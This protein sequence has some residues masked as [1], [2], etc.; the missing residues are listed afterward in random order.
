MSKTRIPSGGANIGFVLIM[1]AL[2][3]VVIFG[4]VGFAVDV[5]RVYDEQRRIQIA[6]DAAALAGVATLGASASYS[7]VLAAVTT[8]ANANS[9]STD[10]VTSV[11]PRCGTWSGGA[12]S[13]SSSDQ[14]DSSS[15]AIEVTIKRR[16]RLGLARVVHEGDFVL[17]ARSVGYNAT[18]SEANCIRPLGIEGSYFSNLNVPVGG[19]FSIGGTQGAGNWG[20]IDI[21]GNSSSGQQ[22][23]NMM[24]SNACDNSF[25]PGGVVS[26]GT[27]NADIRQ[28][29]D[30]LLGDQ[31]PPFATQGMVVALT[32]DF[33]QGNGVV[34][35][36]RFLRVDLLSHQGNGKSWTST[37]RVVD[38][39]AEPDPPPSRTRQ[40]VE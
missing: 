4:A 20:K 34:T 12:F 7:G 40:L 37:F 22:Y 18:S 27:G 2:M 15:S 38:L 16:L 17:T 11:P 10:E 5:S 24:L 29:F 30:T 21:F 36:Q 39:D 3:S 13:P 33:T 23:T 9:I 19:T 14:C 32:S 31:A 1:F 26:Q 35:I 25:V 6:A 28:V 8:I